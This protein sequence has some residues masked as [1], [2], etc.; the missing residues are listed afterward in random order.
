MANT[1]A[2]R[3][4]RVRG[5]VQG[6]GYRPFVYHLA[7]SLGLHGWVRNGADGVRVS[8]QG[9][10]R[11]VRTFVR[12]LRQQH[13]PGA[14][15]DTVASRRLA[16][17][18]GSTG[19]EIR[20]SA[21]GGGYRPAIPPDLG[22]CRA[23]R[24]EV[25]TPGTRRHGYAFTS[26]SHCGPRYSIIRT[27]PYDRSG[28][29]M[30]E[31][32]MCP[33]CQAEYS[34]PADRRF[35]A[36]PIACPD[37]GPTLRLLSATGN[38]LAEGAA[39]LTAAAATV[40]RGHI[41][42][43][44]GL[45]GFQLVADAT[46]SDVVTR[47]RARKRRGAKPF[48]IMFPGLSAV[49]RE[50]RLSA[51]EARA[52]TGATAPIVL[53]ARRARRAGKGRG[54]RVALAVAPGLSRFGV[55]IPTTALHHL[56][57]RAVRRPIVC[58]S[59]NLSEEPL[60][61]TT[62]DAL[63]RLANVA[64]VF[65]THDRAIARPLDDSVL[66]VHGDAP[67]LVRR[68]R[69][70]APAPV[71]LDDEGPTVLAVGG[72][73]KNTIAIAVGRTC[74]LSGHHGD[75]DNADAVRTF[76]RAVQ[77]LQEFLRVNPGIVACDL[78]PDYA[79][80]RAAERIAETRGTALVRV[81]HHH[82]HVAACM[83]EHGLRGPVLG[84]AWDGA[85]H[86]LDGTV[87]GGEVLRCEGAGVLRLAHLRTFPLVGGERA[88]REPRRAALG[89]LWALGGRRAVA[90]VTHLFEPDEL[91]SMLGMLERRVHTPLTSSM[92]R[93]FDAVAALVG[94]R[95]RTTHEGEAAMA[96]EAAAWQMTGLVPG[97]KGSV[98]EE[99][100]PVTV[101]GGNPLVLDWGPLMEGVLADVENGVSPARISFR[102]HLALVELAAAI[103][104]R[105]AIPTVVLTGG[106]FQ[107]RLLLRRIETRL[108]AAG[109]DVRWPQQ[110]P[111]NDGGLALGQA[112]L[113][114]ARAVRGA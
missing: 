43:L 92:G 19:F 25:T 36:Q 11:R 20:S 28:T 65:L 12:Q 5:I 45:G 112:V 101:T 61:T 104:D 94:L 82:A 58:T 86:G 31:F 76:E 37:C 40:R 56:L 4:I 95:A 78:H 68:A 67:M 52:L 93:L 10:P 9:P 84:L 24:A 80:T 110:I 17:V 18:P 1:I 15:V 32:L 74:V 96:L 49:R 30:A 13:P 50:C 22:I 83:A 34:D 99:A 26:C 41:L 39:A 35:H 87:W 33:A 3:A 54:R 73:L 88:V 47:L 23:C 64:D 107:N 69:G 2:R 16:P 89:L 79:S 53:L 48:A 77:D 7:R 57:L 14:V 85:G 98:A 109:F 72:H 114:R 111:P 63:A 105:V 108:S 59:G 21:A 71:R 70:F 46:D 97:R 113:A 6:V 102:F 75:L 103:A 38:L 51:V 55:M 44:K 106:C 66:E 62:T 29:T 42:A 8:V 90:P 100:Y 81:Q 27:L 60:A 91:E